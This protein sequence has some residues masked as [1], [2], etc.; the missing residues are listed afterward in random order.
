MC[1]KRRNKLMPRYQIAISQAQETPLQDVEG[2][3]FAIRYTYGRSS[4]SQVSGQ[5]GQ[6]YLRLYIGQAH[7]TERAKV[8]FAVCDGVGSSFMGDFAARRLG[9]FLCE[10]LWGSRIHHAPSPETLGEQL[11]GELAELRP[12]VDAEIRDYPLPTDLS[13]LVRNALYR[14]R[15]YG[16]ESMF[17]CG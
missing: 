11:A 16:S 5:P 4:E 8:T 10:T 15:D 6:D 12:M 3:G 7:R 1:W 17:V 14:Q 9:D 2:G 13:P